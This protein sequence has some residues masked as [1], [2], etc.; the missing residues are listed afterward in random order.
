[1]RLKR[2][3][4]IILL[5]QIQVNLVDLCLGLVTEKLSK[6]AHLKTPFL[7]FLHFFKLEN[8]GTKNWNEYNYAHLMGRYIIPNPTSL[9]SYSSLYTHIH[10]KSC[11]SRLSSAFSK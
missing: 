9:F 7:H 5:E 1:M 3:K 11:P 6:S 4:W 10:T 8:V 2:I